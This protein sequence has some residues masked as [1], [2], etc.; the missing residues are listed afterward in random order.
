MNGAHEEITLRRML[1]IALPMIVSTA[2][3]TVM[4]FMNRWFVSFLGADHIPASMSGGLSQFVFTSFFA[5]ITGYVNALAAQYYGARMPQRTVQVTSQGLWLTLAFYP[6]L[7]LLIP[8][9]HRLFELAGHNPR[10]VALEF[11]YYRILMAGSFL[12]LLQS[13]LTG[14]FVGIGKTRV[15]MAANLLG[16]VVN[17]PMNWCLVFG[18]LGFPRLGIEGAAF[19]TLGGTLFI[20]LIL[21]VAY[22]R[23]PAYRE[24]GGLRAW[25]VRRDLMGK[26]MRFG[27]PAGCESFINVFAFNVF[28]QLMHSYGP[29]VATA[30]TITFNYDLV[31]FIPMMGVG[32]ATTALTGQCMG[33]GDLRGARRTAFLG[34]RVAWAYAGVMVAAFLAGAP[35]LTRFFSGGFTTEDA[36]I[37]PLANLLLRLAAL[38]ILAD[39]TQVVFSG[40]L[41]GAGDTRWV[42]IVSGVLHWAMAVGALFFIR[43]L[44]L[45]PVTV[46][47]FF[48]AFVISLGVSMFLRHRGGKWMEIHLVENTTQAS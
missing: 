14:Y 33:A 29:M 46:W 7:L 31:A 20:V 4:L 18:N 15:V 9:G 43:I 44:R 8:A 17:V 37:L 19:G 40:A 23:S 47:L 41:R 38:Y 2:S 32:A 10:Q 48:I 26:L 25:A 6:M 21:F 28:V 5:G 16:I 3:E 42:M 27:L 39:G 11:S 22:L 24:H 34:L 1:S 13:A 36:A 45:P 12:F 35:L 30:V